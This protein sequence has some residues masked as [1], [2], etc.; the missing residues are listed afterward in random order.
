MD[1]IFLSFRAMVVLII[2]DYIYF[3]DIIYTAQFKKMCDHR[4]GVNF[5][6]IQGPQLPVC[7]CILLICAPSVQRI[8]K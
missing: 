2:K 6:T 4:T 1:F 7:L 8:V 3:Y 5:G